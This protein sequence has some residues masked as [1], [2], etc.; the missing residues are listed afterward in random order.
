[1]YLRRKGYALFGVQIIKPIQLQY[2]IKMLTGLTRSLILSVNAFYNSLSAGQPRSLVNDVGG[3][4]FK[5]T[6]RNH[7]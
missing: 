5:M 7:T 6:I 4:N 3:T 1:M 2:I